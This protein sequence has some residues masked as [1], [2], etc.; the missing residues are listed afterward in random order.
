MYKIQNGL[1]PE[2]LSRL[3]TTVVGEIVPY[4]LR[5]RRNLRPYIGRTNSYLNSFFPRTVQDWNNLTENCKLA[6]SVK[7]FKSRMN[8]LTDYSRNKL[9]CHGTRYGRVN[10][11]RM[12]LGLSGLNGHRREYNFIDNAD[13]PKCSHQFEDCFHYFFH[14]TAY[15][16]AREILLNKLCQ[17]LAPGVHYSLIFPDN[18]DEK[19]VTKYCSKREC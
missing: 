8:K 18:D 7:C 16:D 15:N 3:C 1:C 14:C 5:N 12:R 6:P 4:N 2:Y 13:C 11:T 17:I 10:H 19:A 9:F